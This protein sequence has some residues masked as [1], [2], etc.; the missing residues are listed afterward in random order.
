MAKKLRC[1]NCD[2]HVANHPEDGCVLA[3]LIQV[4]RDRGEMS[5]RRLRT[6]HASTD[7]DALWNRLGRVVDDLE[8]GVFRL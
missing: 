5:E 8:E 1:P 3:A 7:A 6:L 4:I 2:R